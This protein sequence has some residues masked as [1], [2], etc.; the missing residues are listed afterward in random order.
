[1]SL[2]QRH[3]HR[4]LCADSPIH[5]FTKESIMKHFSLTLILALSPLYLSGCEDDTPIEE[6]A[7][8]VSEAVDPST[9]LEEAGEAVDE[10]AEET[11]EAIEEATE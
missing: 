5:R 1:M 4:R 10:A 8:S 7:E 3:A 6:A 11:S 2:A 9:P